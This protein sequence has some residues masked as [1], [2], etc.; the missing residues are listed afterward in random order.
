MHTGNARVPGPVQVLRVAQSDAD[1]TVFFHPNVA[2][3]ELS[4][5]A[6]ASFVCEFPEPQVPEGRPTP[7]RTSACAPLEQPDIAMP[8][9]KPAVVT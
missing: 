7:H 1:V 4:A 9:R 8:L 2:D 5:D 3:A 6:A